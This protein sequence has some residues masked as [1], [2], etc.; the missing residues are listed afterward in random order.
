M[1]AVLDRALA[2]TCGRALRYYHRFGF[3]GTVRRLLLALQRLLIPPGMVVF[4]CDMS[5]M[6]E[7]DGPEP[8]RASP[9]LLETVACA[10]NLSSSDLLRLEETSGG[11]LFRVKLEE[12]FPLGAVLWLARLDGRIAAYGWTITGRT[13]RPYFLPLGEADVHFFDF[14]VFPEHR[15]RGLNPAFVCKILKSLAAETKRRAFIDVAEWNTPQLYSLSKTPFRRLGVARQKRITRRSGGVEWDASPP[16]T[17]FKPQTA[18]S[19]YAS[20]GH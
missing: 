17:E 20:S 12:R 1:I 13:V 18:A 4:Y 16:R 8:P 5:S 10:K 9:L 14:Y 7:P 15:G 19:S 11:P 3:S 6:C 2:E